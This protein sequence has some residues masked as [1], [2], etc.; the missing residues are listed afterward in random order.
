MTNS[1]QQTVYLFFVLNYSL[2]VVLLSLPT[3]LFELRY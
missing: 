2:L 1:S 3:Y